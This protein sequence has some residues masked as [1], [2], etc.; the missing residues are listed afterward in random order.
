M[1]G[2]KVGVNICI[3]LLVQMLILGGSYVD[4]TASIYQQDSLTMP[5]FDLSSPSVYF[6]GYIEPRT[7]YITQIE[8]EDCAALSPGYYKN[9]DGCPTESIWAAE[10]NDIS[11]NT[12]QGA[13]ATITGSEICYDLGSENCPS[14]SYENIL[15]KARIKVL[16]DLLNVAANRLQLDALIAG[17]D[18]GDSSFDSLGLDYYSTV[19]EAIFVL[20]G[21][22]I[23]SS[24]T[25]VQGFM[26]FMKMRIYII[27]IV[28]MVIF[29]AVTG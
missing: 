28:F 18:D 25:V 20:E 24:H 10:V 6:S 21:V 27:R 3:L 12:F 26:N 22:L 7:S 9:N 17:A 13:F 4:S 1:V 19:E 23:D 15:C 5:I 16:A 8:E 29:I 11:A 2:M 14:G